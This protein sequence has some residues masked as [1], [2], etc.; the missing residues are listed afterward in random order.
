MPLLELHKTFTFEAAHFLPRVPEGHKCARVH[1]HS[2]RIVVNVTGPV[3][4]DMGWVVDYGDI[5]RAWAPLYARLDHRLL[6]EVEGL[7][8]P[9]SE[10]L[11]LWLLARLAVPGARVRSV[12][13]EETCR[14][15]CTA[16]ADDEPAVA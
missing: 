4:P 9:T 15:A 14:S 1:G 5:E 8:N 16:F 10:S 2:F 13:V 6:N 7:E 12:R 3:D 11:A